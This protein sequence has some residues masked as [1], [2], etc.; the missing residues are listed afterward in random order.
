MIEVSA[1]PADLAFGLSA[2]R[3]SLRRRSL[4]R[5]F[6]SDEFVAAFKT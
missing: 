6:V 1:W 2:G 5:L 3:T 4:Q